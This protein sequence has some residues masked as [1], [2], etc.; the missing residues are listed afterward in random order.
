MRIA[1]DKNLKQLDSQIA[2]WAQKAGVQ[3]EFLAKRKMEHHITDVDSVWGKTLTKVLD[4]LYV[5]ESC[6]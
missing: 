1:L 5:P 2:T 6:I 4:D 3:V